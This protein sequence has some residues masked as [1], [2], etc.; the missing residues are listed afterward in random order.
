MLWRFCMYTP[1]FGKHCMFNALL[2]IYLYTL[3]IPLMQVT[4]TRVPVG[5]LM[6]TGDTLNVMC[7]RSTD[8]PGT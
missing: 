3:Y 2:P 7:R 8:L 5:M 4:C 1:A 6:S